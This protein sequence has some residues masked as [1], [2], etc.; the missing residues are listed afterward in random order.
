MM[1]QVRVLTLRGIMIA[2]GYEGIFW[3]CS[4]SRP[5]GDPTDV[6]PS[7]KFF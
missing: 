1:K 7:L 5:R 6:L 3:Q 4:K 2:K